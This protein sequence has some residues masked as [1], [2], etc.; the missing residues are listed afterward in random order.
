[1]KALKITKRSLCLFSLG[2]TLSLSGLAFGQGQT[3]ASQQPDKDASGTPANRRVKHTEAYQKHPERGNHVAIKV[4]PPEQRGR[5]GY[6]LVEVYNYSKKFIN[7][8]DFWLTLKTQGGGTVS[9]HIHVDNLDPNWGDLRWIKIPGDGK[10]SL[11]VSVPK[12]DHM[13]MFD[14][15]AREIKIPYY[16]DLIKE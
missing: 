13:E 15:K 4:T 10:L 16:T 1:M 5:K 6:F 3:P 2:V 11:T 9:T 14:E 7:V 12:V 8:I